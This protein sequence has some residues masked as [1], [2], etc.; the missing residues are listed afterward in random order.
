MSS[1]FKIGGYIVEPSHGLGKL[2]NKTFH[3]IEDK[4]IEMLE[5]Y[6]ENVFDEYGFVW[7]HSTTYSY[8]YSYSIIVTKRSDIV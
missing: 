8:S 5:F 1:M 6:F 4:E 2:S 3:K 7:C